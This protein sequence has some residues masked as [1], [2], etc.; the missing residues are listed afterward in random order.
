ME[1]LLLEKRQQA[2]PLH[3]GSNARV[4]INAA[5]YVIRL[6]RQQS[7]KYSC[8]FQFVYSNCFKTKWFQDK[9]AKSESTKCRRMYMLNG[10][11]LI[12]FYKLGAFFLAES[13]N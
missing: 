5:T 2:F 6:R 8:D 4:F 11:C 3:N 1:T 9:A 10:L 13:P 12:I 7:S